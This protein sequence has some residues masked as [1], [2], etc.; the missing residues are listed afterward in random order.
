MPVRSWDDREIA[1]SLEGRDP[2]RDLEVTRERSIVHLDANR[3]KHQRNDVRPASQ[4]F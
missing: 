3:A 2:W 1:A 4:Y